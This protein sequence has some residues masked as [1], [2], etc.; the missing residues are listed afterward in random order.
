MA[1]YMVNHTYVRPLLYC[2]WSSW[3]CKNYVLSY[4]Y[5]S[6]LTTVYIR[7]HIGS[8]SENTCMTLVMSQAFMATDFLVV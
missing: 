4:C 5:K 1:I 6:I 8:I 7:W 3:K 2:H